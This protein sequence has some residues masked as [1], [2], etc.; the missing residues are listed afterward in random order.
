MYEGVHA[1]PDGDATVSRLA[2]TARE[3]GFGGIVVRNHGDAQADY[4][5]DRIADETGV[6][7]VEGVEIRVD[8]PDRAS[9]YLGSYRSSHTIVAL[10]G[11]TVA[12]NRFAA[13]HP[14]VDVLAHP[15]AGDGDVNHVLAKAAADNGV[16]IEVNL[17]PVLSTAGGPRVQYLQRLRKLRELLDQYDTPYVV[18]ADPRS[19]LQVRAPRELRALGAVIG[20]E[21]EAIDAGLAEW[22]RLAKRNRDRQSESFI[23]P[24][25]RSG[26]YEKDP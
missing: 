19:H 1:R 23:E 13:E 2:I 10:H 21:A 25:V 9:G 4:D 16:R 15:L 6:D 17:R 20:F 12:L 24:G 11:G 5:A 14:R 18:S 3:Y 8:E 7:I 26:Q 22:E